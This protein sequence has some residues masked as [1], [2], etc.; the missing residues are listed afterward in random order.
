MPVP[1]GKKKM[2]GVIMGANI[3]RGKSKAQAK[4]IAE[5]AMMD[6]KVSDKKLKKKKKSK[7]K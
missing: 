3:N 4:A 5:K 1:A 2:Y 6:P 7:K